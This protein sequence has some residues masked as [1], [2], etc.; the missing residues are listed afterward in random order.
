MTKTLWML[1]CSLMMV[2]GM[3]NA[4]EDVP[5]REKMTNARLGEIIKR[6]DKGSRGAPG[7]WKFR[8]NERMLNVITDARAD[9][10]RI[11][12]VVAEAATLEKEQLF[13]LMQAN[14]DTALDSRYAIARGRVWATFIHPLSEL[15]DEEFI[16]GVLQ[17][18]NLAQSYGTTFSSNI[19]QFGGG[20]VE[21]AQPE[22]EQGKKKQI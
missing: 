20:D 18:V 5:V 22:L 11:V 21:Q 2:T 10:M 15:S 9:R 12:A 8:I 7:L 3:A 16:S 1:L 19:I 4:G 14:F 6:L 13:R 17:T